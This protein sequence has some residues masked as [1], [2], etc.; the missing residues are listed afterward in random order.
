[1]SDIPTN[2]V[3]SRNCGSLYQRDGKWWC[4][5]NYCPNS[6]FFDHKPNRSKE[7]IAV[8]EWFKKHGGTNIAVSIAAERMHDEVF[9][10]EECLSRN[11]LKNIREEVAD[12]GICLMMVA[13]LAN[14]DLLEA[15]RWKQEI[16]N[17]RVWKID[18]LGCLSHVPVSDP[19]EGHQ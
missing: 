3:C 12:I 9:E 1:M 17:Q 4:L 16:N 14:F 13:E 19:R 10:L 15:I 18:A 11:D 7:Q 6:Y 2:L 8:I 5:N